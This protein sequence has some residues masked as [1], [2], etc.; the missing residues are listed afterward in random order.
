[1]S[2]DDILKREYGHLLPIGFAERIAEL[3]LAK[4]PPSLWDFLLRLTPRAGIAFGVA[5]IALAV[6]GFTGDAP[7][8]IESIVGFDSLTELFPLQ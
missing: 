1:M 2:V 7:G 3:A 6:L 8:L 5:A 4:A